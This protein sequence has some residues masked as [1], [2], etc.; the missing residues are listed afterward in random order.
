MKDNIKHYFPKQ[1]IL[2]SPRMQSARKKDNQICTCPH[3]VTNEA[4]SCASII[5]PVRASSK[6]KKNLNVKSN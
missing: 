6:T 5:S 1:V 2:G 3:V 4:V